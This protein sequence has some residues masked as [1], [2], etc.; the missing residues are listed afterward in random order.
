M[1]HDSSAMNIPA[2]F[3]TTNYPTHRHHPL[4]Y[5]SPFAKSNHY[6]FSYFPKSINDWNHLSIETIESLSL[7][8]FIDRLL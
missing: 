1:I 2:Y 3:T 6:K 4:Q 5:E 8:L 7:Q